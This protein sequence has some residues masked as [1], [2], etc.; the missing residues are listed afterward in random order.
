MDLSKIK[1]SRILHL[2]VGI[3]LIASGVIVNLI[4]VILYL[5]LFRFNKYLYR[6]IN[7]YLCYTIY[8]QIVFC[9]EWWANI[10]LYVY[11]KKGEYDKYFGKEHAY[12]IMNHSYEIDW[13]VG[14]ALCERL[15]LLGNCKAYAKKSIQYV[16]VIGWAWKCAEFVFLER[17][18]D[19]DKDI[20]SKQ[21]T[22]LAD[23]PDPI[24][25]L[26]YPEGTRFTEEKHQVSLK[27][28][29][30][31]GLPQLKYHLN[32]RTKGFYASLPSMRGKIPSVLDNELVFDPND[33]YQPTIR[34][35]INGKKFTVHL[36]LHRIPMEQVPE[37]EESC[38]KF[39]HDMFEKKDKLRKSF[40]ETG[41]FFAT[42]G[43]ERVDVLKPPRR[44]YPLINFI[45]WSV[46]VL[47]PIL[48]YLRILLFSGEILW[49]SIGIGIIALFVV[50]LNMM[51]GMSD[52]SKS[53]SYG[54]TSEKKVQ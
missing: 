37:D 9:G 29:K 38:N 31:K 42:S 27:F 23:H 26:I 36:Y 47:V 4:Q 3:T 22:E 45:C 14:W 41:D 50:S 28:A 49:F 2:C 53:S 17:S 21:I 32:P 30:E 51:V 20:I 25:L 52:V 40:L 35:L 44:I 1:Q 15:R 6:K 46:I 13:V 43:V 10:D 7:Y 16:P 34:N 11:V 39:M 24:W 8:S 18:F 48:N 54:K 12:C 5:T 33:E 19:K